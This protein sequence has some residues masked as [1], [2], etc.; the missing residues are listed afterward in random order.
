M[1]RQ[2]PTDTPAHKA[3]DLLQRGGQTALDTVRDLLLD[4][5]EAAWLSGMIEGY[6]EAHPGLANHK[7]TKSI[8]AKANKIAGF[9]R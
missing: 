1:S 9:T 8:Y 7:M 2:D 4:G 3:L 5:D 6:V